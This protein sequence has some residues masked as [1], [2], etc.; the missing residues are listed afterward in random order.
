MNRCLSHIVP[1][2]LKEY[3]NK[4]IDKFIATFDKFDDIAGHYFIE[5]GC[6]SGPF[7]H[8]FSVSCVI[9]EPIADGVSQMSLESP[10]RSLLL[11]G[12]RLRGPVSI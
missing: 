5:K 6:I 11:N 7:I 4:V 1:G 8:S 12:L 2:R 10:L 9:V 3:F